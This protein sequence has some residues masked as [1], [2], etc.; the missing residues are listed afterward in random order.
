[1]DILGGSSDLPF[2]IIAALCV[3]FALIA[4]RTPGM[5]A[6]TAADPTSECCI[7]PGWQ[8]KALPAETGRAPCPHSTVATPQSFRFAVIRAGIGHAW[9]G[10]APS[11]CR[12]AVYRYGGRPGKLLF[13]C[14]DTQPAFM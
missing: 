10:T 13:F 6:K 1:M 3:P 4:D 7:H 14:L 12:R 9:G 2:F 5:A 8:K 11:Y